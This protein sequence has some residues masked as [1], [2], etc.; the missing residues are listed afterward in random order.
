VRNP[1]R[2]LGALGVVLAASVSLT[3][4][5]TSPFAAKV[6]SAVITQSSVNDQLNGYA[7]N[8]AWV[9]SVDFQNTVAQG[10]NGATVE[11]SGGP[12]TFDSAFS[13][14]VL[15]EMII[16][17][18]IQ[19]HLAATGNQP[20]TDTQVA[21]RA[22]REASEV[23]WTSFP[24]S[25][26]Q[27]MSDELAE[28]SALVPVPASSSTLQKAYEQY[29]PYLFY[30]VCLQE[31]SAFTADQART[32]AGSGSFTG[33][34]LCYDQAGLETQ[35]TALFRSVVKLSPGDVSAPIKTSYG[36]EVVKL[37]SRAGPALTPG[38]ARVLG[39][40]TGTA[41]PAELQKVV[42]GASVKVNPA[43]GTW[44]S[45]NFAVLPPS[46]TSPSTTPSSPGGQSSSGQ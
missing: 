44:S 23:T 24:A 1:T 28:E 21:A 41:N 11:G 39:V 19:Q 5:D 31:A 14:H 16:A 15:T 8:K 2:I 40:V 36:Y 22:Y 4:C 3:A 17:S 30:R 45:T 38:V 33:A 46:Y 34:Q 13:A 26:R 43:Y 42:A 7:S 12:G 20:E 27:S 10:G 9:A 32:L 18:A 6:D 29:Q 37:V 25:L 35:G